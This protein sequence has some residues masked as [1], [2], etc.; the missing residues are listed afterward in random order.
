MESDSIDDAE[1]GGEWG[2]SGLLGVNVDDREQGGEDKG[3]SSGAETARQAISLLNVREFVK[4]C[5]WPSILFISRS[6]RSNG[7]KPIDSQILKSE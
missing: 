3:G 6:L 1:R 7:D 4:N 2:E 5:A